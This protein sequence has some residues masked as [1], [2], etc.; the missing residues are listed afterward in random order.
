MCGI[1][2]IVSRRSVD[3]EQFIR[4]GELNTQ[5]GN[6]AFGGIVLHQDHVETYRYTTPFDGSKIPL[7]NTCIALGHVKAP[8]GGQSDN[9]AEVHPF[10]NANLLLAHN[11]LLLNHLQFPEWRLDPAINV[12]SQVII[13]GIQM[14]LDTG[15]T[16][17]EA[18]KETVEA[19]DGQQACWLWHKPTGD[20]YLWR[21]MSPIYK[22][23]DTEQFIFSS[24]KSNAT[25]QILREGVIYRFD[26]T[27]YDL[28]EITNF[29][30]YNP[31]QV[32]KG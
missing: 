6:L 4:L 21:V 7:D 3:A 15:L 17:I 29:D 23:M 8:T 13:G 18:I 9:I 32:R 19:L 28:I 20:L 2:G 30:Y 25:Q 14:K 1:F 26:W 24:T 5:R 11:G 12:D 31:Y 10:E 16:V 22:G 27:H